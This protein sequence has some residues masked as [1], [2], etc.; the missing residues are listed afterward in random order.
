MIWGHK[1]SIIGLPLQGIPLDVIAIADAA[2][3]DGETFYPH[4]VHLFN[5]LP[6]IKPWIT[7]VLYDSACDS[8]DLKWKFED[9]LGI[10]LK[11]SLNPRRNKPITEAFA[12]VIL[13]YTIL[14]FLVSGLPGFKPISV[15]ISNERIQNIP[16][17][18]FSVILLCFGGLFFFCFYYSVWNEVRLN[19][20]LADVVSSN[21]ISLDRRYRTAELYFKENRINPFFPPVLFS[22]FTISVISNKTVPRS[23]KNQFSILNIKSLESIIEQYPNQAKLYAVL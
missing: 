21:H 12:N 3:F 5:Q 7:T 10:D 1:A 8:H 11:T 14:G 22:K 13:F 6:E 18:K 4:L 15:K 23:I 17:G 16:A 19:K 20:M 9:N 2:T